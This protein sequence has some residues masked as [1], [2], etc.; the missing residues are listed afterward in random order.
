MYKEEFLVC[1]IIVLVGGAAYNL[2]RLSE[3]GGHKEIEIRNIDGS[4]ESGKIEKV[5][6][7]LEN[8]PSNASSTSGKIV[9]SKNG[10]AYYFINCSGVSRISEKN[11]IY[12][13]SEDEASKAGYHI[14]ANCKNN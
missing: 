6:S 12:F 11:K 3:K 9:A 2:G 1:L 14:A 7:D 4:I 5:S 13:A 8:K 10:K